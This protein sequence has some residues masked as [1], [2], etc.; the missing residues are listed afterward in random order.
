MQHWRAFGAFLSAI[1]VQSAG[2]GGALWST[3]CA[4][5]SS[6]GPDAMAASEQV[7]RGIEAFEK[8]DLADAER[9]YREAIRL[10]PKNAEG[11]TGLG[12]VLAQR[13]KDKEAVAAFEAAIERAPESSRAYSGLAVARI[14]LGDIQ[15]AR[16]AFE[17]AV[18]LDPE[19]AEARFG[20]GM[21]YLTV[22]EK[23][24]ALDQIR[25]LE[26]LN[27]DLARQLQAQLTSF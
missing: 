12:A 4:T 5:V 23:A 24:R 13:G 25:A 27:A 21:L 1:F 2:W 19:S 6:L 22:G 26:P 14:G 17:T 15:G 7:G 10:D 8:E 11:Y 3:G 18:S 9:A 20:L 16:E